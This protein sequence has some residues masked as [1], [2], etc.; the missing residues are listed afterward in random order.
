MEKSKRCTILVN[1]CDAYDDLWEPFFKLFSIMWSDCPYDVVLN[2]ESKS[3]S[4]PRL[5]IKTFSHYKPDKK[6][7]WGKRFR[8]HLSQIKTEYVV[9]MLDDFFLQS[10]PNTAYLERLMDYMDKDQNVA[11]FSFGECVDENNQTF[12][13]FSDFYERPS[14]G[15]YKYNLQAGIWKTKKLYSSIKPFESPWE[16][17][18]AGNIRS[19]EDGKKYLTLRDAKKTNI[20]QYGFSYGEAW[21]VF[22]GKW[23]TDSVNDLFEK[24][25][26]NIDFSKRSVFKPNEINLFEKERLFKKI[27][28]RWHLLRS[29]EFNIKFII[30]YTGGIK[31]YVRKKR[32]TNKRNS[33]DI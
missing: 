26:I 24:Y 27:T 22:R 6:I 33:T 14:R 30:N 21:G 28:R 20:I 3:Y 32:A 17:E 4:Y 25:D 31:A 23:V 18:V 15:A 10:P 1:S 29:L 16:W 12:E 8:Y 9:N 7:S 5:D 11:T 2:T 19:F 13:P